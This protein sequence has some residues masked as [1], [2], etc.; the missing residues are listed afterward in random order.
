MGYDFPSPCAMELQ[1][2]LSL[3]RVKHI[4]S[5]YQLEGDEAD[6]FGTYLETLLKTYPTVLLELAL[7]ETLVDG[8]LTT[9]LERGL[10][11]LA[12]AHKKL[13]AWEADAIAYTIT[14]DQFQQITGLDPTPVFGK[15]RVG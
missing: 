6:Y 2:Q 12:K 3:Q 4:V 7:A 13:K 11:F 9:P 8:W 5:S 14:P 1:D 10:K 15:L